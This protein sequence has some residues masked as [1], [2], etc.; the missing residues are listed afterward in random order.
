MATAVATNVTK[1]T[2]REISC[3]RVVRVQKGS[4]SKY[5][6]CRW[7]ALALRTQAVRY[8]ERQ[9]QRWVQH[10]EGDTR[11][12]KRLPQ[13]SR[14]FALMVGSGPAMVNTLLPAA[15]WAEEGEIC[16]MQVPTDLLF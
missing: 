16:T 9:Q 4:F 11:M 2:P 10:E 1:V 14:R 3:L 8:P 5:T 15:V 12:Q 6:G 7:A 13:C